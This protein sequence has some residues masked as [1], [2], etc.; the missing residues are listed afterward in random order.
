MD[1]LSRFTIL[2]VLRF[3]GEVCGSWSTG[4]LGERWNGKSYVEVSVDS[5]TRKIWFRGS[6]R[7]TM[8]D[9]SRWLDFEQPHMRNLVAW[10]ALVKI[11]FQAAFAQSAQRGSNRI[12]MCFDHRGRWDSLGHANPIWGLRDTWNARCIRLSLRSWL[13]MFT[14][15]SKGTIEH[16]LRIVASVQQTQQTN[17]FR[18]FHIIFRIFPLSFHHAR[19]DHPMIIPCRTVPSSCERPRSCWGFDLRAVPLGRQ[20]VLGRWGW[21]PGARP[22]PSRHGGPQDLPRWTSYLHP[23]HVLTV[24]SLVQAIFGSWSIPLLVLAKPSKC[25]VNVIWDDHF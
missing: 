20:G 2:P 15:P 17:I 7:P 11:T 25:N 22:G 4:L 23:I 8:F 24:C 21:G 19:Y 3:A 10:R 14:C 18:A 5:F 6:Q 16:P 9:W 12:P 13:P 1:S